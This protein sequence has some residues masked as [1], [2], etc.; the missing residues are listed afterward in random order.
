VKEECLKHL[1]QF[2]RENFCF[3]SS[4]EPKDPAIE[5]STYNLGDLIPNE[6]RITPTLKDS[7][8]KKNNYSSEE[9]E[10]K[11]PAQKL[12]RGVNRIGKK[13]KKK[14]NFTIQKNLPPL[15][16]HHSSLIRQIQ[17]GALNNIYRSIKIR[18]GVSKNSTG[19][20]SEFIGVSRNGDNWQVMVNLHNSKK[21]AGTYPTE[22]QA[23]LVNDF[24]TISLQGSK[25]CTNFHYSAQNIEMMVDTYHEHYRIFKPKEFL[26][27]VGYS[28]SYN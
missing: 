20:R 26:A 11:V 6:Q 25:A 7:L 17:I 8:A 18:G 28:F 1:T 14:E 23:A 10:V 5:I 22:K 27:K 12:Q 9:E 16:D 24:F 4:E 13:Y 2:V 19:R 3:N 21:Y 15:D